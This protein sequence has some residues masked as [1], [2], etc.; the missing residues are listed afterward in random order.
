[1]LGLFRY[2]HDVLSNREPEKL[3]QLDRTMESTAQDSLNRVGL[4]VI[5]CSGPEE[6]VA[7]DTASESS[8]P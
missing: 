4:N 5:L 3:G 8:S 1:M 7:I 6:P 2:S